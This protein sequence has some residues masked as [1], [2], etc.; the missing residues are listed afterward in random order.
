LYSGFSI[1]T[2]QI[3]KAN[4]PKLWF[5]IRIKQAPALLSMQSRTKKTT[6]HS[7]A[8]VGIRSFQI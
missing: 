3:L 5:F 7:G 1:E 6:K 2:I 8:L 4:I